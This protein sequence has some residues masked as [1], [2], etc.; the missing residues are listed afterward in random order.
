MFK[1]GKLGGLDGGLYRPLTD[2]DQR[3]MH[4]AI[5]RLLG[6]AGVKVANAR[7]FELFKKAG[8]RVNAEKQLVFIT[9]DFLEDCVDSAPSE[10]VLHARGKP[11]NN[12]IVGGKRVHYGSGGTALNILDLVSGEKRP[13]TLEDVQQVSKLLD[14]LENCHFQVIPVYPNELPI[15][16]VDIN[17]FFAAINNTNKHVQGGVYT[18]EGTKQVVEM[19]TLI[20]GSKE[21]LQREPFISFITCVISPLE[22]DRAYGDL[23]M[24]CAESGLPLS[25]PAEPLT[26]ATG[27]VTIAG[28]VAQLC[29]ET[30]SGLC[31]AQLVNRGTP[32]LMACTSTSTDLRT[33]G[34]ASG[35]VEE[36]LINSCAAQMAQF[37]GLPFYGTAGQSDSKVVDGQAGYEGAITNLL[38]GMAGG[39]FIHDALGLLEFCMTA[40]YEKYVMD[41]DILGEVMRVLKGVEVTDE[42]LAVDVIKSVGPGG[43]FVQEDHTFEHMREEHY[44]PSVADRE[45]R[46]TWEKNGK[47]DT[48]FRCNEM[49]KDILANHKPVPVDEA[50]IQQ[51]RSRFP[52]FV[53]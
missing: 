44:L 39:N 5:V 13:S 25:M 15:E 3:R 37:Y 7:A 16:K 33:M 9:K 14:Y 52:N 17:R 34:Y 53:Q 49:A 23:L 28:N 47:K 32:V 12:I 20:A 19:A 8:L 36:G 11:E 22:I 41:N 26:G 45:Q 1:R 43:N 38:V 2:S 42:T 51:I 40:S 29:A 30:L 46:E 24:T 48:Y 50:I 10:L 4:E 18:V 27:P 31:L 21:K 6:E 35:S